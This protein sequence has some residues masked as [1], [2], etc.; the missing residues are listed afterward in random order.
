M[1]ERSG[2]IVSSTIPEDAFGTGQPAEA[3]TGIFKYTGVVTGG[4]AISEN[5]FNLAAPADEPWERTSRDWTVPSGV[6]ATFN[7]SLSFS[8]N[9]IIEYDRQILR[10]RRDITRPEN[11]PTLAPV[12][13]DDWELIS[14]SA[15]VPWRPNTSY[16]TGQILLRT[17]EAP[18][19]ATR[20]QGGL[21]YVI[22]DVTSGDE[23]G[24]TDLVP[25]SLT[26]TEWAGKAFN[27]TGFYTCLLY[28]SPSPRDS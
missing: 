14:D 26:D 24:T 28:T 13:G 17:I 1:G 15:I 12:V 10:A 16:V 3:L 27:T 8:T 2:D 20:S 9:T 25:I 19:T 23:F 7:P 4:T 6:F 21:Y 22:A 11:G 18:E 5:P